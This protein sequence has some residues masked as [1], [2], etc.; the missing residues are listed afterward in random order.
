VSPAC[1]E[2]ALRGVITVGDG[3]GSSCRAGVSSGL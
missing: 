2:A 1:L 3:W